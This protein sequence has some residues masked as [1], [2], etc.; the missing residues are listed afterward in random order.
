[1]SMGGGAVEERPRRR[2]VASRESDDERV[3][4]RRAVR[5][6]F[7]GWLPQDGVSAGSHPC[8]ESSVDP[9]GL[10]IIVSRVDPRAAVAT[11]A[12]KQA[13]GGQSSITASDQHQPASTRAIATLATVDR[14]RRARNPTHRL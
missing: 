7:A 3:G 5:L 12:R 1:M 10:L 4:R 13:G 6:I 2:R 11:L 8:L 14:L 9:V